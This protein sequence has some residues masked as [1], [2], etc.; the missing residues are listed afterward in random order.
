MEYRKNCPGISLSRM[1]VATFSPILMS[2]N[3]RQLILLLAIPAQY[4][5]IILRVISSFVLNFSYRLRFYTNPQPIRRNRE[6]SVPLNFYFVLFTIFSIEC[7]YYS[8]GI[9]FS[10]QSN[11]VKVQ[12]ACHLSGR[13]F[14]SQLRQQ[15]RNSN[16]EILT[17]LTVFWMFPST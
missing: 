16:G 8:R 13:L 17:Q 10:T 7:K 3:N 12:M 2:S 4:I 11:L 15:L 9:G 14:L 6:V 5:L 1:A